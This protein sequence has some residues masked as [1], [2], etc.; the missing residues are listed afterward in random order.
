MRLILRG[1]AGVIL[2]LTVLTFAAWLASSVAYSDMLGKMSFATATIGVT[3]LLLS[4]LTHSPRPR[5]MF[6]LIPVLI[7]VE[8]FTVN[9]NAE[10]NYDPLPPSEQLSMTPP[11]VA[12]ALAD[13]DTP[14][15]VDGFRGLTDNY[16]SLYGLA[17]IHGISPLFLQGPYTI[18]EG[19][20]PDPV[21]WWLFAVRYV[22]SDWSELPVPAEIIGTGNDRWGGVHLFR[23]TNPRPFSSIH[24]RYTLVG[25]DAE[26]FSHLRDLNFPLSTAVILDRAP[27][28]EPDANE[29]TAAQVLDFK[30]ERI[31]IAADAADV[32]ILVIALPYYPGWYATVDGQPVDILKAYGAISAVIVPRG[33]HIIELTYNPLSYRVGAIIS[34][35]TWIGLGILA[36][37]SAV[38]LRDRH[39]HQQPAAGLDRPA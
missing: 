18:I 29:P 4:W 33:E 24:Y 1:V 26:A 2:L 12:Q 31:S 15:L 32:G 7:V 9:R 16:G 3:A 13:T 34:L 27:G 28:I 36:V 20:M 21:A 17:D 22:F 25:S 8:L 35:F 14:F 19:D 5:W 10:S 30:P 38:R 39:V 6:W 11:L 37:V 23:L